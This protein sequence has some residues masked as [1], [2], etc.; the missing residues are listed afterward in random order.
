MVLA[1]VGAGRVPVGH[2]FVAHGYWQTG[3]QASLQTV[4]SD[5]VIPNYRPTVGVCFC[6]RCSSAGWEVNIPPP[7]HTTHYTGPRVKTRENT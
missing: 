1:V 2:V 7:P 6:G 4:A 5:M 3:S